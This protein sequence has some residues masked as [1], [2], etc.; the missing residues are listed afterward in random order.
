V[1]LDAL[2]SQEFPLPSVE[3]A[4]CAGKDAAHIKGIVKPTGG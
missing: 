3:Q 4:L 1:Q 2:V